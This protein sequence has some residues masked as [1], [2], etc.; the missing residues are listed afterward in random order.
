MYSFDFNKI[1]IG[2]IFKNIGLLEYYDDNLNFSISDENIIKGY[3]VIG[4]DILNKY[5]TENYKEIID[6]L[7]NVIIDDHYEGKN[8]YNNYINNI[9][10]F[11]ST[12]NI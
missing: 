3:K 2:L 7:K 8:V 9:Y 1:V 4:I 12:I 10:K 11:D 5:S 6:F